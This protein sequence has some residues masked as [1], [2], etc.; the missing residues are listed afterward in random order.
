MGNGG[1]VGGSVGGQRWARL[2]Q[3][4]SDGLLH[5]I[6][7][8]PP[9]CAH[10]TWGRCWHWCPAPGSCARPPPVCRVRQRQSH[11][12]QTRLLQGHVQGVRL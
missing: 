5:A 4:I 12:R 8:L 3:L 6:R 1:W 11:Q 7:Q 9:S 10:P 2:L